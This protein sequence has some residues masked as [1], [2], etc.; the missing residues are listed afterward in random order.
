MTGQ[1]LKP[2]ELARLMLCGPFYIMLGLMTVE[3]SLHAVT[4]FLVIE[5]GRDV[6]R[7]HFV[8]GDLLTI[9]A[10]E[11][12]AYIVGA[13]SWI[14]AERTGFLAY[15]RYVLRFARDNREKTKLLGDKD[16]R[17]RVEPFLTGE[18]FYVY[19]HLLYEIEGDL[20]ILLALILNAIVLGTQIDATLPLAYAAVLV[21]LFSMQWS[22]RKRVSEAYLENQRTT[23][24]MTAQ[25]YTAWDNV[26]TGN[27]YNLRLWLDG[28]K[29]KLRGGLDAQIK[30]VVTKEGLSAASGIVGLAIVFAAM[31]M[32]A[33]RDVGNLEV[34]IA[35]AATL[36]RQ[37]EMTKD[38]HT[39]T[40]GWNDLLA[41]WARLTGVTESFHPQPDP[42]FDNRVKIEKLTLRE[43]G[44]AVTVAKLD[45]AMSLVLS[46][47]TGRINV[48]GPNGAGKSTLLTS[49]KS[50]VKNRAYY[51][52]TADRLS[53]AFAQGEDEVETD[54]DGDPLPQSDAKRPGFSSGERQLRA[55]QEIVRFT[56]APIYLL[57]EWD[58]NLDPNNRA[59]ADALVE[60][61]ARR[62]RVVEISHRD[63][64]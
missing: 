6:A 53:F 48:R 2:L 10:S 64:T 60:E 12:A 46:H 17:E 24:R 5:A 31:A 55:L 20:R 38:V 36:P 35:L 1:P 51:W 43:G 26:F 8:I 13:S 47:P 63:R 59:A 30:A 28:F 62:A 15:G 19:F 57:D 58:A 37:I 52:P 4:T 40:S 56:D 14:F 54:E 7:G 44:N 29:T 21:V 3:A 9:L 61:L 34:M 11:S 39:F 42:D 25:G 16:A 22:M 23:N 41:Q 18:T 32:I 45:D 33:Y 27:R 49:L 50:A